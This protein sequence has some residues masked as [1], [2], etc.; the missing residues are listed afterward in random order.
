MLLFLIKAK[1]IQFLGIVVWLLSIRVM[2]KTHTHTHAP[3]EVFVEEVMYTEQYW[4]REW[5]RQSF[6]ILKKISDEIFIAILNLC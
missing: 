5:D 3:V 6:Y 2:W 1:V 4:I